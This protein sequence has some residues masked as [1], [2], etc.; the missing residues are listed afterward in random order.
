MRNHVV[1]GVR[2]DDVPPLELRGLIS[3]WLIGEQTRAI[4]TPNPEMI[5]LARRDAA[6][7]DI[8]NRADLSLPDGVGLRFALPALTSERLLHRHTGVDTLILIAQLCAVAG[9]RLALLGGAP[10][11]AE[12]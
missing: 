9:K 6:F 12:R 8:L 7:R 5:L 10:C 2:I 3:D 4:V 11:V 1:F